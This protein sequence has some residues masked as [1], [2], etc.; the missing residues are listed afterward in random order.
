M[1]GKK[2]YKEIIIMEDTD[3]EVTIAI[4]MNNGDKLYLN[5]DEAT[6][7]YFTLEKIL[8]I[9]KVKNIQYIPYPVYEY[10]YGYSYKDNYKWTDKWTTGNG[11]YD[12]VMTIN[13]NKTS[14][15]NN[16]CTLH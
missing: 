8:N 3:V 2:I 1:N 9:P 13:T 14:I 4:K 5:Q 11:V 6:K 7:L 10:P 12:G 15:S 16:V